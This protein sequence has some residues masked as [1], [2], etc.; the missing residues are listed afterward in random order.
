M[1]LETFYHHAVLSRFPHLRML[2]RQHVRPVIDF[3][4]PSS[5]T[6][7]ELP[8]T[9]GSIFDSPANQQLATQFINSYFAL[10]DGDRTRAKLLD[11]YTNESSLTVA[12]GDRSTLANMP[13]VYHSCSRNLQLLDGEDQQKRRLSTVH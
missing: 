6:N 1:V 12:V 3:G 2:D 10:Y 7:V 5:V 11:V 8:P 13:A 4:L 9:K